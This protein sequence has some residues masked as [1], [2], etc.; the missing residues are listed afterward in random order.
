MIGER[1]FGHRIWPKRSS[2]P[3]NDRDWHGRGFPNQEGV[4]R[5]AVAVLHRITGVSDVMDVR[6]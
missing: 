2:Y 3:S 4:R 6:P 5:G 1:S